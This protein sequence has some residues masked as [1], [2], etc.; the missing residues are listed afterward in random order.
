MF[1]ITHI[2][3]AAILAWG[4]TAPAAAAQDHNRARDAVAAGQARPLGQILGHVMA[5][6]PGR[7]LD[8]G[9]RPGGGGL[10]YEIKILR[11]GGRVAKLVVDAKSG[12]IRRG[13]CFSSTAAS[14][15]KTRK[16]ASFGGR[17]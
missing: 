3:A 1:R 12:A 2:L 11:P 6:C 5:K 17:P 13:R 15:R 10:V 14:L 16:Y 4:M 7:F 9:L 8:A